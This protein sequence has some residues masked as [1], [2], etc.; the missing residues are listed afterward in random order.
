MCNNV[1][2]D[3]PSSNAVPKCVIGD[4]AS[5][6]ASSLIVNGAAFYEWTKSPSITE[7]NTAVALT[8][9]RAVALTVNSSTIFDPKILEVAPRC[10]CKGLEKITAS[11]TTEF[12]Y[13]TVLPGIPNGASGPA[14]C[15]ARLIYNTAINNAVSTIIGLDDGSTNAFNVGKFCSTPPVKGGVEGVPG[16]K[17]CRVYGVVSTASGG[18]QATCANPSLALTALPPSPPPPPPPA[19]TEVRSVVR[20]TTFTAARGQVTCENM[21]DAAIVEGATGVPTCTF[22]VLLTRRKLSQQQTT[23]VL[24]ILILPG[25]QE[26]VA[27][28]I[29][30]L[31]T[32]PTSAALIV[33]QGGTVLEVEVVEPT[34]PPPPPPVVTAS[35]PPPARRL[36]NLLQEPRAGANAPG[37]INTVNVCGRFSGVAPTSGGAGYSAVPVVTVSAP[38]PV[39]ATGTFALGPNGAL[40]YYNIAFNDN[41]PYADNIIGNLKANLDDAECVEVIELLGAPSSCTGPSTTIQPQG[42]AIRVTGKLCTSDD[43]NDANGCTGG[44]NNKCYFVGRNNN[45]IGA[46]FPSADIVGTRVFCSRA[47]RITFGSDQLQTPQTAKVEARVADGQ[48]TTLVV[49]SAGSGYRTAPTISI[50]PPSNATDLGKLCGPNPIASLPADIATSAEL[51]VSTDGACRP[52]G[53]D[54]F[55][56]MP[57]SVPA[58]RIGGEW[59]P[60]DSATCNVENRFRPEPKAGSNTCGIMPQ[61]FTTSV[62][63]GPTPPAVPPA[64]PPAVPPATPPSPTPLVCRYS[65]VYE[66]RPLYSPCNGYYIASGTDSDCSNNFVNLRRFNQLGGKPARKNWRLATVATGSL[67]TPTRVEALARAR[68]TTSKYLAAPNLQN[69]GYQLKVGGNAWEWQV[70]PYPGSKSCEEVNL[71]SQN[72][73]DSRAFLEVPRTCTRF[74][75]NATDG[76]RQ[77]FRV[78]SV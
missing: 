13:D 37:S 57:C 67:G 73:L 50:S 16:V 32:Q 26:V 34:A 35:P 17:S 27:T 29:S 39:T 47:P 40:A 61:G 21:I 64:S 76:G 74:L 44:T 14:Q 60:V 2:I 8:N 10:A 63:P 55:T 69:S 24:F 7:Y 59:I 42:T 20:Y 30:G 3:V 28:A 62:I 70:V 4:V 18:V 72:N 65:G 41:G 19:V 6:N 43:F 1:L 36:R 25:T 53:R 11:V 71:I 68:C 22:D 45:I 46:G 12:K 58:P 31:L 49:T 75:Y 23:N 66:L 77:R 9:G 15:A 51:P 33:G 52:I 48:V 5:F 56:N 38:N 54:T 78:R